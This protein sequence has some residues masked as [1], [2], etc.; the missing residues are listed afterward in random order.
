V[1]PIDA[2]WLIDNRN[3][4]DP[5]VFADYQSDGTDLLEQAAVPVHISPKRTALLADGTYQTAEQLQGLQRTIAR[6]EEDRQLAQERLL[7]FSGRVAELTDRM[8]QESATFEA[9]A[10]SQLELKP[11]VARM[12]KSTQVDEALL[13]HMR[14]MDV[15]IGRLARE[16]ATTR[17]DLIDGLRAEVRLLARTL[18][19]VERD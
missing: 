4:I 10:E 18:G 5:V 1:G 7:E 17:D 13:E 6:G 3:R 11:L 8:R 2:E 12:E 16:T 9:M 15:N 19:R 14:S